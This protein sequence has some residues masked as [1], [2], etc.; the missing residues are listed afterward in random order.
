MRVK[1]KDITAA[2]A[3]CDKYIAADDMRHHNGSFCIYLLRA[4]D[5]IAYKLKFPI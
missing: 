3:W 4:E 5:A 1:P 2:L